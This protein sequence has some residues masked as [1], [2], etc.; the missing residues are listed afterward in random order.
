MA[1][2]EGKKAA[3]RKAAELIQNG[4]IVGLG[5]GSTAACFIDNL[6]LRCK[7]GLQIEAVASSSAS[8]EQA[9]RGQ[10]KILDINEVSHI[11]ITVDGADEIDAKKRMVK[12]GGGAHVREKILA[13][14]S[15]EVVIIVDETKVVDA[16][17]HAKVPVEI[18]RYG[19]LATGKKLEELG[20]RGH[21]RKNK[22]NSLFI[23]ENGN[24]LFDIAFSSP[25]LSPEK[26]HEK[27]IHIP[28]V[29]DTG[30]FFGY[31]GRVIIGYSDG[32]TK[33]LQ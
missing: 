30:F 32:S 19:S 26:D 6:I 20:Y 33:T 16:I 24:C 1:I 28:G 15:R 9:R 8:A 29:I 21:W 18:L 27:I 31:A 13:S 17:G 12:G 10:L 5:T 14:Y 7:Q 25:L 22:D 23:T 2:Q 3:G 4:Q 11:D